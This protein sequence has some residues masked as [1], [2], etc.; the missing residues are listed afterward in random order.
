MK[1]TLAIFL[2]LTIV[3]FPGFGCKEKQITY[4]NSLL[5]WGLFD[6]TSDYDKLFSAYKKVHPFVNDISYRKFSDAE[7]YKREL[8]NYL[9]AGNGPDIF[10]IN[11]AWLPEFQD[12]IESAPDYLI[13]E[14]DFKNNFVDVVADDFYINNKIWGVP[15]TVDSLALYYN[16]DIFNA[17][18]I[19]E[20]PKTWDELNQIV[21]Q[22]TKIDQ[23]GN[24]E[25]SAVALGTYQNIN[26]STDVLSL[27][28][29]QLGAEMSSREAKVATFDESVNLDGAVHSPAKEALDYY[30]SF[31]QASSPLY[32]WNSEM[33]YSIDDFYEGD[34]AMILN[35][36]YNYDLIKSKNAKL[37][38]GVAEV[39]Q[40]SL[41]KVGDQVNYANYWV[42]VVAKNKAE[43]TTTDGI[44]ITNDMQT[45]EAWQFLKAISFPTDKPMTF[46]NVVD[47]NKPFSLQFESDLTELYLNDEKPAAR[48]DLIAKQ[49]NVIKLKPFVLGNLIA[50]SWYQK[51]PSDVEKNLGEMIE[52]VQLGLMSSSEAIELAKNRI[53]QLMK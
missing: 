53:T 24:V 20:P 3:V 16:K 17:A 26:R 47:S 34:T 21:Q 44:N 43:T 12:K 36:A 52:N 33:D 25:Q 38:F 5:I 46:Y 2:L 28:M 42:F 41:D 35:Y 1:K 30:T 50:K 15:L 51:Y 29:M 11:S 13:S 22:L 37:N 10:M 39:P 48:K 23:Y 6:N 49:V 31:A 19:I 32:T 9:A 8:L 7:T 14:M 40:F 27:M 45:S 4:K 18:G